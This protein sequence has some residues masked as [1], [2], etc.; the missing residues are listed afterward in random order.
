MKR[1]TDE[2]KNYFELILAG[3]ID[4]DCS[5]VDY[6]EEY[7]YSGE[8]FATYNEFCENEF[9][10]TEYMNTLIGSSEIIKNIYESIVREIIYDDLE[11]K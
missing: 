7:G 8:M 5:Y 1:K 6:L 11:V 9:L 3:E 10:D 2:I 4:K